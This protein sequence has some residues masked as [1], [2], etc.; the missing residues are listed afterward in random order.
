MEGEGRFLLFKPDE[1]TWRSSP[2][3]SYKPPNW[4]FY[5]IMEK[6]ENLTLSQCDE[7]EGGVPGE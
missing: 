1:N 6:F 5:T 7:E 4:V 2:L 3:Q